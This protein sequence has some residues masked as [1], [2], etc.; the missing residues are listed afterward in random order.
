MIDI[1]ALNWNHFFLYIHIRNWRKHPNHKVGCCLGVTALQGL[2]NLSRPEELSMSFPSI[3]RKERSMDK[4]W[5]DIS[6]GWPNWTAKMMLQFIN[7]QGASSCVMC[8]LTWGRTGS[9]DNIAAQVDG[10]NH[11]LEVRVPRIGTLNLNTTRD[12][13]SKT[14]HSAMWAWDWGGVSL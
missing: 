4:E 10:Q 11:G 13:Y 7:V 3:Y 5:R 9:N 12:C 1:K 6:W 14:S 8:E 2:P